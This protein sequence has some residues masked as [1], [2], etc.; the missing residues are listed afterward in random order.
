MNWNDI[1]NGLFEL[2]GGVLLYLNVKEIKKSRIVSGVHWGPAIFFTTWGLWNLH[3][4]PSL[5]QW[6]SFVGGLGVVAMNT[7]W[8]LLYFKYKKK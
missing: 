3:Y 2:I 1:T 6:F 5:N 4:Y 7:W 8:I